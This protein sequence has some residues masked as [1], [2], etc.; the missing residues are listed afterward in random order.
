MDYVDPTRLTNFI[1]LSQK[2]TT[3]SPVDVRHIV[4]SM[5]GALIYCHELGVIVRGLTPENIMIK[6]N[7]T[8]NELGSYFDVKITDF[9][10]AVLKGS[11][12]NLAD[13]PL[14]EW[15]AV[16]YMPPEAILGHPYSTSLDLWCLGVLT[17]LMLCGELPF[18][19]ED[20]RILVNSIRVRLHS[21][22][23]FTK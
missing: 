19:H 17:F 21:I 2:S 20:D 23:S 13:H 16:P 4:K 22:H 1:N 8:P 12:D 10:Q 7:S 15:N 9:S 18:E 11:L 6:K 5:V 14:F 3:L